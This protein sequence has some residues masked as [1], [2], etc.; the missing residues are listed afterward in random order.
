MQ[1]I[2]EE[3]RRA[4]RRHAKVLR[5][6]PHLDRSSRHGHVHVF[7]SRGQQITPEADAKSKGPTSPWVLLQRSSLTPATSAAEA[8]CR[9]WGR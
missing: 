8:S 3:Q 6:L 9:S 5:D 4:V 7:V 2:D 1:R